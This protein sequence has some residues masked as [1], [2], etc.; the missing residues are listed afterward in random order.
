MELQGKKLGILVSG[1]PD[2]PGFQHGLALAE[3]ALRSGVRV[4]LYCIDDAVP[5]VGN[6]KLQ[7]LKEQGLNLFAC[8]YAAERRHFARSDAATFAG[9]SIV[10]DLIAATDKFVSFA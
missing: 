8:A 1:S 2:Q 6:T 7:A 4:Y 9:L 5:G 3:A 10:S